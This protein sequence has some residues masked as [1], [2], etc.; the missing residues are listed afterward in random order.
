MG[1]DTEVHIKRDGINALVVPEWAEQFDPD[2]FDPDYWGERAV[3]VSSGGRGSAWFI[4]RSRNIGC[5]AIT[6]GEDWSES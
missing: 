3:P 4:E 5:F 2:W 1:S 6:V